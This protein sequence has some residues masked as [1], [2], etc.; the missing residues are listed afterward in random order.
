MGMIAD[1][2]APIVP[3]G[4]QSDSYPVWDQA[5]AFRI[6]DDKRSPG[7]PARK[8]RRNVSSDTYYAE[9]YAL[10]IPLTLE[11]RE[12]MDDAFVK[13]LRNGRAMYIKDKLM[14]SWEKRIVDL[15]TSANVGSSSLVASAWN[16]LTAGNSNPISDILTAVTNIQDVTGY[17]PNR[18]VMGDQAWRNFRRHADVISVLHGNT[19][20]IGIGESRYATREGAANLFEMDQFLVGGAYYNSAAEGQPLSLTPFW[21]DHTYVYYAPPRPS[22]DAP[23]FMYSF[24]WNKPALP[25]MT[26]ERFPY[27]PKTKSEEIEMGY[28]QGEKITASAL[29][30]ILYHCNSS[31]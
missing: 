7:T 8:I 24:R 9:N 23:S 21:G 18:I 10:N 4:K 3:V 1:V 19:G 5:D 14:L 20:K 27:D 22:L 2:I 25:N 6:E 31:Q 30:F 26:V 15:V 16:D 29:G 13:E 28:Y 11:D 12:N 17:R